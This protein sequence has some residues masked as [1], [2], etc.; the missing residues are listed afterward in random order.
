MFIKSAAALDYTKTFAEQCPVLSPPIG[1]E[2]ALW[3]H[4]WYSSRRPDLDE[5]IIMDMMQG[6][7]I[8]NDR[9]IKEKHIFWG[10]D[11]DNPRAEIALTE[12]GFKGPSSSS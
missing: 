3:C 9:Q 5:S 2:V 6:R 1:D 7:V 12:V 11:R 10:L 8:I 4:I